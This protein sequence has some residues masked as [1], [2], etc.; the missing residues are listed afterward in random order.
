MKQA[1]F[2][3]LLFS[4]LFLTACQIDSPTMPTWDVDVNVP[5]LHEHYYAADLIDSVNIISDD[6]QGLHFVTSGDFETYSVGELSVESGATD[7]TII[8]ANATAS[9]SLPLETVVGNITI[10]YGRVQSGNLHFNIDNP[11]ETLNNVSVEFTNL[12]T[13]EGEPLRVDLTSP[14]FDKV[15][16]LV[17]CTIGTPNQTEPV[18]NLEFSISSVAT[19]PDMSVV[20]RLDVAASNKIKFS[21]FRGKMI[22]YRLDVMDNNSAI[23]VDYP[24]GLDQAVQPVGA[25]IK[26]IVTNQIGFEAELRGKL[27]GINSRTGQTAEIN[28]LDEN[29]LPYSIAPATS[30]TE[31]SVTTIEFSHGLDAIMTIAPT[32]IKVIDSYYVI[33]SEGIGF[34]NIDNLIKADYETDMPFQFVIN[35]T[36]IVPEKLVVIN[37]SADNQDRIDKNALSADLLFKVTNQLPVGGKIDFFLSSYPDPITSPELSFENFVLQ[38]ET[39]EQ[40]QQ[41][42][43]I[44]LSKEQLKLFIRDKVYLKMRITFMASNG[45][46]TISASTA[47]QIEVLS[48]LILKAHVEE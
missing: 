11:A 30:E 28:I 22:D 10:F 3:L 27:Q 16:S 38:P 32:S 39:V 19:A 44:S 35:N 1:L 21:D 46:I 9:A 23:T 34:V 2:S 29:G 36:T 17:G 41:Q 13:Q 14:N 5:L 48:R 26:L 7:Q 42:F 37:I 43:S 40:G 25:S 31:A 20:G 4:L 6:N 15:V 47:D 45:P 12:F 24:A 33:S 8:P 18:T